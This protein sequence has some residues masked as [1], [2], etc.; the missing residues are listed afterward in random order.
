[1]HRAKETFFIGRTT[2]S[3]GQ[4]VRDEDPVLAGRGH[5]FEAVDDNLPIVEQATAAPGEKRR[6]AIPTTAKPATKSGGLK[7]SDLPKKG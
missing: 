6:I 5:L 7:T 4:L 3:R 1:M 2:V